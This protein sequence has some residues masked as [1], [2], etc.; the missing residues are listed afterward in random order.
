M[1]QLQAESFRQPARS[2]FPQLQFRQRLYANII[3]PT[4]LV[5]EAAW[6]TNCAG[7]GKLARPV[8]SFEDS[9]CPGTFLRYAPDDNLVLTTRAQLR[10]KQSCAAPSLEV[11]VVLRDEARVILKAQMV[12]RPKDHYPVHVYCAQELDWINYWLP[13]NRDKK[14]AL[15]ELQEF[16]KRAEKEHAF[17]TEIRDIVKKIR[18]AYLDLA[19]PQTESQL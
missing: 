3:G 7:T 4:L 5:A 16:A 9:V 14:P 6:A 17:S 2:L 10:Y 15:E 1:D 13:Y 18:S 12:R 19:K 11:S 8:R